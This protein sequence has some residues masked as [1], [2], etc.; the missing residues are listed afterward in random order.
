LDVDGVVALLDG[1]REDGIFETVAGE[2]P[3]RV[4]ERTPE[5]VRALVPHFD[6][7][8]CT[9]WGADADEFIAPLLGL[10]AG[11]PHVPF[12]R[13]AESVPGTTWKLPFVARFVRD[14]PAA[15]VDDEL[16]VDVRSWAGDREQPTLLV[17]TDPRVGL[18]DE[19]V[20]KLVGFADR[21]RLDPR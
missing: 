3:V 21:V 9:L 5:R 15:W 17:Q 7:V 11:L 10:P 19:H 16:D 12:N 4:A 8:Y 20:K 13:D 18:T 14:R 6:L 1:N 2:F